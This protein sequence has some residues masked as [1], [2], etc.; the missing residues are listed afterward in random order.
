MEAE[1][2]FEAKVG[3]SA[4]QALWEAMA[5]FW[6]LWLFGRAVNSAMPV[7]V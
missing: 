4:F 2:V 6:A 1:H 5:M 3:D 7:C